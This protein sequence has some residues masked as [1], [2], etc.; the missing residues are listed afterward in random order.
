M[1]PGV[2]DTNDL[3]ALRKRLGSQTAVGKMLGISRDTIGV[4]ENEKTP[5]PWYR[6]ALERLLAEKTRPDLGGPGPTT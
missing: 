5:P 6:L 4:Y 2:S 3:R 1:Y